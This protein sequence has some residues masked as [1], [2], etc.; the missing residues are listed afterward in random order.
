MDKGSDGIKTFDWV[1]DKKMADQIDGLFGSL[2]PEYLVPV[3]LA[4]GGEFEL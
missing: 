2:R 3:L 1:I 4:D